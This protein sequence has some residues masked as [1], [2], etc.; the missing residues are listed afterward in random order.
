M[1]S[2]TLSN[3]RNV[4]IVLALAGIVDVVPGGGTGA[5]V[6]LQFVSLAFLAAAAWIGSRLYREHRVAL[7]SLGDR[8]RLVLYVALGA[9]TVLIS[10]S[11]RMMASGPGT[12][13]WIVALALCV[14]A[15][16]AVIWSA[17]QY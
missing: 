16:F 13:V 6:A 15:V 2:S 8:R 9:A 14:Y 7:Y 12:V 17:R 5:D 10:A 4:A 1:R 3:L 11:G